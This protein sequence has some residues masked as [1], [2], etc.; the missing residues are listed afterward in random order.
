MDRYPTNIKQVKEQLQ[1]NNEKTC[2]LLDG[3]K[4]MTC[5]F[6]NVHKGLFTIEL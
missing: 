3:Y 5:R 4:A 6:I 2:G 1:Q